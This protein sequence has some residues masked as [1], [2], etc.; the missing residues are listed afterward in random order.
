[1]GEERGFS[2]KMDRRT[3]KNSLKNLLAIIDEND[4]PVHKVVVFGSHAKGM[5]S[6]SSDLDVCLIF[7]DRIKDADK[8]TAHLRYK[9]GQI[10]LNIDLSSLYTSQI[11]GDRMSSFV[12]EIKKTSIEAT[13]FLMNVPK[14]LD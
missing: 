3:A 12:N 5:A 8:L 2:F 6:K 9:M 4:V 13:K 1:M 10:N 14:T 7:L 11:K